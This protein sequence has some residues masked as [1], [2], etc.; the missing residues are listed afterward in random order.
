[1]LSAGSTG[2]SMVVDRVVPKYVRA[3]G[4]GVGT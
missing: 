1:M 3:N 2:A 4:C